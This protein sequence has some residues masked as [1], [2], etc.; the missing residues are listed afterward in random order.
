MVT[1]QGMPAPVKHLVKHQ[2]GR[3]TMTENSGK[4]TNDST[5]GMD[6]DNFSP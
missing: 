3:Y 2:K 5:L 1:R 4:A 6:Q